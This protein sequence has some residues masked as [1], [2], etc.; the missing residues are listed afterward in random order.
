VKGVS[1]ML[2]LGLK[3]RCF[4]PGDGRTEASTSGKPGKVEDGRGALEED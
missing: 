4:P 2:A 3:S 1:G